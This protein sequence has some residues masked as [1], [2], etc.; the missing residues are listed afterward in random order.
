M[1]SQVEFEELVTEAQVNIETFV[2]RIGQN[3]VYAAYSGGKDS[4]ATL[5][6]SR[7]CYPKL[8]AV[9][10][11][12]P[13]EKIDRDDVLVVKQP[14][15][16][17]VPQFLRTVDL[18]GQI[19]GTRQDED[20]TVI[21]DGVE[22]HRSKMPGPM[23]EKGVFDL[24]CLFPLW[25]WTEEDVFR[26]LNNRQGASVKVRDVRVGY[27]GEGPL[28][29]RKT[30]YCRYPGELK[31][32]MNSGALSEVNKYGTLSSIYFTADYITQSLMR[33]IY[34]ANPEVFFT[35]EV[36]LN[37]V[38]QGYLESNTRYDNL[39][40]FINCTEY[41]PMKPRDNVYI[42]VE[43]TVGDWNRPLDVANRYGRD[44]HH[45]LFMPSPTGTTPSAL[46]AWMMA[47]IGEVHKNVRVMPPV[48]KLLGIP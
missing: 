20:K 15:L 24:Q 35:V 1:R 3:R 17:T 12:H 2:R 40:W 34:A 46:G 22:I 44:G 30:L 6:L 36:P 45:V 42:K 19:D 38:H 16:E 41:Q 5:E 27:E 18:V 48:H 8:L 7:W 47:I 21:F 28:L 10:N 43:A 26:Y 31:L 14:K 29:G 13:G 9:H 25:N 23:T 11:D 4:Q 37:Q 33:W 32:E 39:M